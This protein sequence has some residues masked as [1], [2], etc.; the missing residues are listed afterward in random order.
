MALHVA[1]FFCAAGTSFVVVFK[2]STA[3]M[4]LGK[5]LFLFLADLSKS[6][7][8]VGST[9]R[10]GGWQLQILYISTHTHTHTRARARTHTRTHTH[11]HTHTHTPILGA[12]N[13]KKHLPT[14]FR[15]SGGILGHRVRVKCPYFKA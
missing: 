12:G 14:R 9:H 1:P 5:A 11:T 13:P 7:G 4:E 8:G 2:V 15:S 10:E 3:I 6:T